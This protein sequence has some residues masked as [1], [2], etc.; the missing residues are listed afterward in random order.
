MFPLQVV[1]FTR[2]AALPA[3]FTSEK[4][5]ATEYALA[6][7][8]L[9]SDNEDKEEAIRAFAEDVL[10]RKVQINIELK[11][12]TGPAL[13]TIHDPS[14]N[15]DIGKQLVADGLVLVEKRG[16]RKLRELIDQY[17]AAQQAALN[18]HLAIWKYG[19][20]TQDD[21]PEFSR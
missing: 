16:E 12:G 3:G 6:L 1:P 20:I 4:P 8:Q 17:K 2:L 14:T 9:P 18:A 11:P 10:N 21:A 13:A 5:F 7:V 15:I 19:D